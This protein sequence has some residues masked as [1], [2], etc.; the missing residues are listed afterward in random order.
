MLSLLSNVRVEKIN[1]FFK[2]ITQLGYT[3]GKY[4]KSKHGYRLN[5]VE[6]IIILK[7]EKMSTICYAGSEIVCSGS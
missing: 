3:T 7:P 6:S 1:V 4:M 5:N 2:W